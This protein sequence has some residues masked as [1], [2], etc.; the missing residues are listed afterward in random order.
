MIIRFELGL[1]PL[2]FKMQYKKKSFFRKMEVPTCHL[3][4]E[5]FLC[6]CSVILGTLFFLTNIVHLEK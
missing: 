1:G 5:R 2:F 6:T 4:K 3:R